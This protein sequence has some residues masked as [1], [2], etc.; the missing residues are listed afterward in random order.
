MLTDIYPFK[1]IIYTL[2]ASPDSDGEVVDFV[3]DKPDIP[4]ITMGPV[5]YGEKFYDALIR[6]GKRI[7]FFTLNDIEEIYGS[8]SLGVNGFYTDFVTPGQM[9]SR[10][11]AFKIIQ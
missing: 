10:Q 5:R 8:I 2:Y 9:K 1:S 7:Y 11:L 3:W 6:A 4:V